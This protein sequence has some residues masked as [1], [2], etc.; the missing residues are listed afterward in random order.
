MWE[1]IFYIGC[2][3]WGINLGYWIF[4]QLTVSRIPTHDLTH[5]SATTDLIIVTHNDL[6]KLKENIELWTGQSYPGL[7][8]H[9]ADDGSNDGTGDWVKSLSDPHIEY[10]FFTKTTPGKKRTLSL[11]ISRSK[12]DFIIL[13]DADGRPESPNWVSHMINQ[14]IIERSDICLGYGP[15]K[16]V[17]G[18]WVNKLARFETTVTAL[19]Y[20]TWTQYGQPYMSVGRNVAYR[21]QILDHF[22]ERSD[23]SMISGDDDLFLQNV[24]QHASVSLCIDPGS[25]VYSQAPGTFFQWLKQKSRHV[26]ASYAY[27]P[28]S[29][30]LL[31]G[32][33][34]SQIGWYAVLCGPASISLTL[35]FVRYLILHLSGRH[36]FGKLAVRDL[37]AY[38]PLLEAGLAMSYVILLPL[39]LLRNKN[40]W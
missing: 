29:I 18:S 28:F 1:T 22:Y 19:Q 8:I 5:P 40:K 31:G 25:H 30:G 4:I 27:T 23:P 11:A 12:A 14:L 38:R 15:M 7:R 26:S 36:S 21:R 6:D 10:E 39:T 33:A 32:F 9:I 20:L 13:T 3:L 17:D 2:T 37:L 24:R 35:F 34:I 16:P